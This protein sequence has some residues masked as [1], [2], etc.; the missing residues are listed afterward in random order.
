[1]SVAA[2]APSAPPWFEDLQVGTVFAD[3]PALV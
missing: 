3:A 2:A 1:M